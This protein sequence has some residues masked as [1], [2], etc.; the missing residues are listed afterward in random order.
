MEA[1]GPHIANIRLDG[2][3][4]PDVVTE[5]SAE[6]FRGFLTDVRLEVAPI[7]IDRGSGFTEGQV[8]VRLVNEFDTPVEAVAEISGLPIRG[9]TVEPS[10]IKL[11]AAPSGTATQSV[12][13][14]FEKEI[15][16]PSLSQTVL[17]AKVAT[18]LGDKILRAERIVPVV[19]DAKFTCP[20]IATM[21]EIDGAIVADGLAEYAGRDFV[22]EG[23]AQN[24]TGVGD[25]SYKLLTGNSGNRLYVALQVVDDRVVEGDGI[26]L[27]I[28][29]RASDARRL[30]SVLAASG[31][32]VKVSAPG[33]NGEVRVDANLLRRGRPYEGVR[34]AGKRTEQGYAIELAIPT[35][36][37]SDL[38]DGDWRS[39]Q[40]GVVVADVD[41]VG[42]KPAEVWWRGIPGRRTSNT[43]HAYFVRESAN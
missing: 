43:G 15:D 14:R 13:V 26:E 20:T 10:T 21:P 34:A 32:S 23:A 17:I 42:E 37:F 16:F 12:R 39:F 11:T 36:Y 19:I 1:D 41:E 24:Y 25:L 3:L 6:R 35:R 27:W 40:M 5:A 29:P 9:L 31:L 8:D 22:I 30:E 4:P 18:T 33:E 28:D 38:Q 2:I 7:L